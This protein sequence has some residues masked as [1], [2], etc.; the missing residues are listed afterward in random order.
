MVSFLSLFWNVFIR[1]LWKKQGRE[2]PQKL[3]FY[4]VQWNSVVILKFG[5]KKQYLFSHKCF[6]GNWYKEQPIMSKLW[7]WALVLHIVL[8]HYHLNPNCLRPKQ[9]TWCKTQTVTRIRKWNPSLTWSKCNWTEEHAPW[10]GQVCNTTVELTAGQSECFVFVCVIVV[11]KI[12]R[13]WEA[14]A[15]T[16]A[17]LSSILQSEGHPAVTPCHHTPDTLMDH[18]AQLRLWF[19]YTIYLSLSLHLTTITIIMTILERH[20]S[21]FLLLI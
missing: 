9:F 14:S 3:V 19:K 6:L 13:Q 20:S 2:N 17:D 11:D 18:Y 15:A 5:L 8:F 4:S 21:L 10:Q 16:T 7:F 1:V 12:M